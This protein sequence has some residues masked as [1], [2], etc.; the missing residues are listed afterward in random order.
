MF[1]PLGETT[2]WQSFEQIAPWLVYVLLQGYYVRGKDRIRVSDL[3]YGAYGHCNLLEQVLAVPATYSVHT[4]VSTWIQK[5]SPLVK[6]GKLFAK[7]LAGSECNVLRDL[8]AYICGTNNF[9]ID[10]RY[11]LHDASG[12]T[13]LVLEQSKHT[14]SDVNVT[15]KAITTWYSEVKAMMAKTILRLTDPPTRVIYVYFSNRH[16]SDP[17]V[18][19]AELQKDGYE[20]LLVIVHSNICRHVSDVFSFLVGVAS[21][22][23]EV[24]TM[25]SYVCDDLLRLCSVLPRRAR[26][27]Q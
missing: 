2:T 16:L 15:T 18:L 14:L 21:S 8:G 13:V 4:E 22:S 7:T 23:D 26:P 9:R 12:R 6:R 24:C 17:D 27:L 1:K 5:R 11:S 19:N 25:C 10:A 20:D 3:W